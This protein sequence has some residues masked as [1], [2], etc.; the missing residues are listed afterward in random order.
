METGEWHKK[1]GGGAIA[2]AILDR[3]IANS[4]HVYIS[5]ESLRM[6]SGSVNSD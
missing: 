3:A 6:Q 5:G 4:Y 1:L 2:D